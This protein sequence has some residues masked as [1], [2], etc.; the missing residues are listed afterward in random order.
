M[1]A[2]VIAIAD[3]IKAR[4]RGGE[5]PSAPLRPFNLSFQIAWRLYNDTR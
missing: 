5:N 2:A 1:P 4:A 3:P